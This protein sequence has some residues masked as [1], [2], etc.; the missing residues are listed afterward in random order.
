[1]DDIGATEKEPDSFRMSFLSIKMSDLSMP[2]TMIFDQ[3][4]LSI[5]KQTLVFSLGFPY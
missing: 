2:L 1:M 3:F 4:F 5:A